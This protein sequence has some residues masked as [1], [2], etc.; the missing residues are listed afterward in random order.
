MSLTAIH[1]RKCDDDK[2]EITAERPEGSPRKVII[3]GKRTDF[4]SRLR[5]RCDTLGALTGIDLTP[6]LTT[7]SEFAVK[8]PDRH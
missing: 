2:L 5:C 1:V 3:Q 6:L 7:N 8:V 4:E